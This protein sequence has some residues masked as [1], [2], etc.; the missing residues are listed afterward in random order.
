M[1]SFFSYFKTIVGKTLTLKTIEK[2]P[3]DDILSVK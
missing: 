2:N 3:G 1:I